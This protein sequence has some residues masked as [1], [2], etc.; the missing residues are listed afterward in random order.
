MK[1]FH[2]QKLTVLET[3]LRSIAVGVERRPETWEVHVGNRFNG[4]PIYCIAERERL[5]EFL[6]GVVAHIDAAKRNGHYLIWAGG[7]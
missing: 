3:A 1:S 4:E 2:P 5:L 6:L 7:T